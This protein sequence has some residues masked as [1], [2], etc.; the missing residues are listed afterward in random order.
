MT[1]QYSPVSRNQSDNDTMAGMLRIVLTKWLQG[2]DD[3]LPAQVLAYNAAANRA[4]V[5]PLIYMVTTDN[6]VVN[7]AQVASVP[8]AQFGGGG[9]VLRFPI[10]TG[11]LG[12]IK[13]NDR[14]ISIF[15]QTYQNS[16]PNTQRKHSFEDALFIPET[17][18]QGVTIAGED[19]ANA[20]LQNFAGTV[21]LAIW[22]DQLKVTS[23]NTA[24]SDTS[25]FTP[26][27]N[28]VLD[29]QSTTRA[30]RLPRMTTA[31]KLA[32]PSPGEGMMV[33]D[34]DELAVSTYNGTSWS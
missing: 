26:D 25:G 12:W 9:F 34:K 18:L 8:V 31:Q 17:M 1:Q 33:W 10:K 24:I 11:D 14:D 7:R 20:V 13:A 32:I 4:Q 29:L 21:R 2:M 16:P 15:K 22:P 28:A 6:T 23:P 3:M 30:F 19:A 27:P 5:Q